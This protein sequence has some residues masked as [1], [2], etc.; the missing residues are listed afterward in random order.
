MSDVQ[1]RYDCFLGDVR[2]VLGGVN[3]STD[4]GWIPIFDFAL[5]FRLIGEA[6]V[7]EGSAVFEFTDSDHVIE[8]NVQDERVVVRTN[9]A[10]GQGV[11]ELS[12]FSR[13]T[14]E[15]LSRVRTRIEGEFPD[16]RENVHYRTALGQFW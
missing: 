6:L 12:E 14:V 10:I 7:R 13:A 4:W 8:F 11:V 15:F 16:L 1:L 2:F 5:S 3:F 9:Y